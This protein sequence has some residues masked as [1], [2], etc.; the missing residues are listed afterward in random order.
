MAPAIKEVEKIIPYIIKFPSAQT[1]VDYDREADVIYISF[2]KPEPATDSE[3][4]D[5]DII[6]RKRND[7]IIGLTIL[8]ASQ[9][10]T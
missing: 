5:N 9:Y 8:H 6:V 10:H 3:L 4:L 2:A 7:K 1:W